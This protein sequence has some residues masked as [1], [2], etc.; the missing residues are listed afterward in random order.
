[1][2]YI[3]A[4]HCFQL[5]GMS[6]KRLNQSLSALQKSPRESKP[7]IQAWLSAVLTFQDACK[8]TVHGRPGRL[9]AMV[10]TKMD[11]LSK[12]AS[13]A[14][15]LANRIGGPSSS[16]RR[17]LMTTSGDGD[18][19]FFPN[20][21]S[22]K[23]RRLLQSAGGI[24]ADAVVAQDGTGNYKTI[25]E[26]INAASGGRFVIHVKAGVYKEKIHTNKDGITLIGDG[27]YVT[28]I[29]GDDSVN[30]GDSLPNSATFG[31]HHNF[32]NYLS[33]KASC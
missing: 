33:F 25:T 4:D 26:A 16:H 21:V 6:Q 1:M 15:A 8:D 23:D 5:M 10:S 27:K 18:Y 29:T 2:K 20:W 14:L 11:E 32:F 22:A 28:V 31:T 24:G 3:C 17:R 12:H 30:G 19:D 7:D 13:N 9:P